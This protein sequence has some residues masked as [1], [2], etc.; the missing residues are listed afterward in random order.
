M[1]LVLNSNV[2]P[3][4][5]GYGT[6]LHTLTSFRMIGT[7]RLKDKT[8]A[9]SFHIIHLTNKTCVITKFWPAFFTNAG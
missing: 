6:T 9:D 1:S 8:K 5:S 3:L 2:R 7:P 4:T